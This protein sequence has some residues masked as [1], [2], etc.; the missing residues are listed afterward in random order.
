M[1]LEIN[2]AVEAIAALP[3]RNVVITGGEPLLQ[4]RQLAPL[5]EM[6]RAAGF[7]LEVETNGTVAPGELAGIVDQWNVSPKLRSSGNEGLRTVRPEVLRAF[8]A[9]PAAFLK[10]VI[11]LPGD[12]DEAGALATEAG[13]VSDR[14]ILMPEGRTAAEL[15][16]KSTWLAE[17]CAAGG[18]RFSSRLHI[19]IWG[20]R[21]G[22]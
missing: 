14:V 9:E 1:E 7:R 11:S 5:V 12:V 3:P 6:L 2:D 18:F 4:R 8:A 13:F 15:S 21:R 16:A 20:D 19:L 22:V 10:F 17:A